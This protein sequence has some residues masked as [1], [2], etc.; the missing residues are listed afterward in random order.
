NAAPLRAGVHRIADDRVAEV[1]EVDADLMGAARAQGASQQRDVTEWL[2]DSVI[3]DRGA[4]SA[5]YNRH[6]FAIARIASDRSLDRS[7]VLFRFAVNDRQIF[8]S[9]VRPRGGERPVGRVV[10]RDDHHAARVLVQTM[11][12]A[13]PQLAAH[14]AQI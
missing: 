6:A 7:A 1:F 11:N 10:L 9:N 4:T 13:G 5:S 8:F 3:G 12:D 2:D 14:A